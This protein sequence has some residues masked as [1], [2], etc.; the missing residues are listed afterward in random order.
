MKIKTLRIHYD[1]NLDTYSYKL[2]DRQGKWH[3]TVR[4]PIEI[5]NLPKV[6]RFGFCP[7]D[8]CDVTL[9]FEDAIDSKQI[10]R[11]E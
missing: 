1:P 8:T 2:F 4:H 6:K 7:V 3:K 5:F 9:E 11:N 10:V